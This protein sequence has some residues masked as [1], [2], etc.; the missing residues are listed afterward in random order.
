MGLGARMEASFVASK[1]GGLTYS[2]GSNPGL[3]SGKVNYLGKFSYE[4]VQDHIF[5]ANALFSE[6]GQLLN[7]DLSGKY[8]YDKFGI[9][10]I[11][12][13]INKDLDKRLSNDLK[14]LELTSSYSFSDDFYVE[15]AS[16]Y[17]LTSDQMATTSIGF[18]FILGSWEYKLNQEYLEEKSDEFS[19]SAI[20]DD[21]CTR[22]TFSF[23]N[24]YQ[25]IGSSA[26]VKALM[27]RFQL[28]PFANV[29][30]SQGDDQITF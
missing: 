10:G 3:I 18:G 11:Y 12:Q 28:K 20:Y 16:R 8:F 25:D 23:E 17:D 15:A 21:D 30:F 2:P 24:R 19:L 1:I 4:N 5:V 13:S 9:E 27:L 7:S 22:I 26:P 14:S 6:N 29:V